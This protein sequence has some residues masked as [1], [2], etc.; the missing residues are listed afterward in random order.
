MGPFRLWKLQHRTGKNEITP[1]VHRIVASLIQSGGGK[2]ARVWGRWRELA[3]GG[4]GRG[5]G[6]ERREIRISERTNP[7]PFFDVSMAPTCGRDRGVRGVVGGARP[8]GSGAGAGGPMAGTKGVDGQPL[9]WERHKTKSTPMPPKRSKKSKARRSKSTGRKSA[10]RSKS[11]GRFRGGEGRYRA[12]K[13]FKV[14]DKVKLDDGKTAEIIGV[15]PRNWDGTTLLNWYKVKYI[16][17]PDNV[18]QRLWDSLGD[19]GWTQSV[20]ESVISSLV[21]E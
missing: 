16:E 5:G 2:R 13:A 15:N 21:T 8:R 4:S 6:E 11:G 9:F 3:S 12:G 19:D 1:R 14:G 10:R 20:N 7:S 18:G 17:K